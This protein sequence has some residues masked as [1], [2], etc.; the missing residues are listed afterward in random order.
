MNHNELI[1]DV[2]AMEK[3]AKELSH[4]NGSYMLTKWL[5]TFAVSLVTY[6]DNRYQRKDVK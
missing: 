3:E 6:L 4:E 5:V 2:K 1:E